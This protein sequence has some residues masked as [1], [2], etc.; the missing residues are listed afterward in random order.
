MAKI[1]AQSFEDIKSSVF[2][3]KGRRFWDRIRTLEFD[4][5][6]SICF[7]VDSNYRDDEG[8]R[9]TDPKNDAICN[10]IEK[11]LLEK[12]A[13]IEVENFSTENETNI[14][15]VFILESI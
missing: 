13:N 5:K 10:K 4:G 8:D 15:E 1:K 6:E 3:I 9:K 11:A 12:Y 7:E 14:I 2:C